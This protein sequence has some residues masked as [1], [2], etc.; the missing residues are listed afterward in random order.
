MV[1]KIQSS[2]LYADERLDGLLQISWLAQLNRVQLAKLAPD[3]AIQH[4][5]ADDVIGHTG[6]QAVY[7]VVTGELEVQAAGGHAL[8]VAGPGEV[9]GETELIPAPRA[10]WSARALGPAVVARMPRDRFES[11]LA[12]HPHLVQQF[13]T[14]I[15]MRNAALGQ[16]LA[17]T[18][19]L[20]ATYAQ[21]LWRGIPD[22]VAILPGTPAVAALRETAATLPRVATPP[23]PPLRL[24]SLGALGGVL[25]GA[26]IA[27]WPGA[28][29]RPDPVHIT[30]GLLVAAAVNWLLGVVPDYVVALGVAVATILV[31]LAKPDLALAGFSS[32]NWFLLLAVWVLGAAVSKSGLLYRLA[33][34]MLIKLPA[35]FG[36]QA[37]ALMMAGLLMTPLLPNVQSRLVMVA[38]LTKELVETLRLKPGSRAISGLALAT[39]TGFGLLYFLFLNGSTLPLLAWS[40]LPPDVQQRVTWTFWLLA[41]LPLGAVVFGGSYWLIRRAYSPEVPPTISR[42][43]VAV[44]L[45]ILGP[46][47][48]TEL[49]T[50]AV[51]T[52]TL[53]GFVFSTYLRYDPAWLAIIGMLVLV[54]AGIVDREA[55]RRNVDWGFL[56]FFG[57][58]M[59][60][61]G[62]VRSGGIDR[63]LEATVAPL[64]TG[65]HG[66]PFAFVTAVALVTFGV[67]LFVPAV[68]SV[69]L[70]LITLVPISRALGYSPFVSSLIVLAV[71][72]NFVI[73]QQNPFYMA[74]HAGLDQAFS[75]S[76]TRRFA[77]AH[78]LLMWLGIL[79]SVPLWQALGLLP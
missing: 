13:Q 3:I 28:G 50:A 43:L 59:S 78:T 42:E 54:S 57:A 46:M 36:G 67:R 30:A 76:S 25:L 29:G 26:A 70:L 32:S 68:Q 27:L 73:P 58:V 15:L 16:E 2:N 12:E 49:I 7:L 63:S 75:H 47:G 71:A 24:R 6:G 17:R 77:M 41:A 38:P 52:L 18:R 60:F 64:F 72:T 19:E 11:L 66:S 48:R 22:P 34:F 14:T 21:E 62:V 45:R 44:Q 53:L 65:S 40:L 39:L 69:P 1:A 55:L 33:L 5:T 61:A 4:L 51:L 74:L 79:V 37:L 8:L 31:G 35:T 10:D 56:L 9:L 20:L 23:P